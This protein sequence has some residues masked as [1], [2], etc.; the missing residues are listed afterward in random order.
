MAVEYIESEKLGAVSE[1]IKQHTQKGATLSISSPFFTIFAFE[2]LSEVLD[3]CNKLRFLFNKPN[4]IKK[5]KANKKDV[6]EFE[7]RMTRRERNISEF[8]LEIGLKNNLDQNQIANKCY[9]FI[10]EKAEVRSIVSENS[11]I[12]QGIIIENPN[13]NSI[14]I[15]GNTVEFSKRGLG[16][17][18]TPNYDVITAVDDTIIV[19]RSR[20]LFKQFFENIL[21]TPETEDV[22]EKLL[23]YLSNLYKENSPELIY[24]LTLYNV[25]GEK[26]INIDEMAKIKER[27]GITKSKIWNLLYNFQHDA[28]VGAI[29]K[30]ELFNGC[31]IADSVG[32][33]KTFEA[34]AIIKYYELR[35][36]RVLVLCPKKLRN[37]WIG[38]KQNSKTNI[39]VDDRFGYSVLNHTDLSRE[40]GLTGD[41]NLSTLNWGNYELVVIDESHNFRN[42]DAVKGHKT[43]YQKLMEDIIRE[44]VNTKVLMLSAT[45]V[46]NSFNDLKNQIFLITGDN[47]TAFSENLEL[48]SIENTLRK[49]QTVFNSWSKQDIEQRTVDSLLSS[50]GGDFYK[51]LN[52]VTIARSR[53]HIQTYYDTKDIGEFPERNPPISEKTDLDTLG[54]FPK[55]SLINKMIAELHLAVYSPMSYIKS[56]RKSFYDDKYDQHVNKGQS[57]LKQADREKAI[58]DLMRIN[59]LKR[60][61]S[62]VNSFAL[63]LSRINS[64]ITEMLK[65]LNTQNELNDDFNEDSEDFDDDVDMIGGKIKISVT[66]ID[67][68]KIME[69]LKDDQSIIQDLLEYA[70]QVDNERDL[71][72]LTLK[73]HIKKK[74]NNPINCNNKKVIIF[75]T[76]ADTAE[77]IYKNISTW[78]LNNFGIYSALVTGSESKNNH[79]NIPNDF[80]SILAYFSPISNHF[81]THGN[82]LDIV[83]ATDCISEGQNLQDCD[84]LV[85]YDIHWNPVRIVQRFG[86]IDRIGSKNKRIQMVNFWPNMELEEYINLEKR[87]RNKMVILDLSATADDNVIGT[88]I[89]KN[90]YDYR[91]NQLQ[92]LQNK[93]LDIEDLKGG[94]SITDLTMDDFFL[95]LDRFMKDN[96]E[97]LKNYPTGVYAITNS[98]DKIQNECVPGVIFCL[99]QKRYLENN[100][101]ASSLYPYY[102]VYIREDGN[103]HISNVFPKKILDI[104]KALCQGKTTPQDHLI[105]FFNKET[106]NGSNMKKYTELLEKAVFDI[107]GIS[108][109]KGCQSIFQRGPSTFLN[110]KI[111]GLN[112]F[113]LISFLVVK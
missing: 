11:P 14:L 74:I 37:N 83:I 1:Y 95:S 46:N 73:E 56:S 72:L 57:I 50:F 38:F 113:E 96:P 112:D 4:F 42:N 2:E 92:Q 64:R 79:P 99:K 34:L 81:N 109:Q 70:N 100:N 59:L 110:N 53:K 8:N 3:G 104:Y 41:V 51:L 39:L 71:K 102:I 31:I 61:E 12:F 94:I 62:S 6:K 106:T 22:K 107:K 43:R 76:F 101:E 87:V 55:L 63:T 17:S 20:R 10:K 68:V 13:G 28:V 58:V 98:E 105:K 24:Y 40:K 90:K 86:R 32:L 30:L 35:H 9:D 44:G 103:V 52:A 47:D 60:M 66:D 85:N 97:L 16:Y 108:E 65:S 25:F 7:L 82:D 48:P 80:D 89:K 91:K 84:Y 26:L 111:T 49:A 36:D 21:E 78:I 88:D 33:G 75:T 23:E 18:D 67:K 45:P 77:Y 27:T 54:L 15:Q 69:D 5:I 19:D 29:K 93:V